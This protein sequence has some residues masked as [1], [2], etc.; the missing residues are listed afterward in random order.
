MPYPQR[1]RSH[2]DRPGRHE[3]HLSLLLN[4]L[5]DL[6]GDLFIAVHVS[7]GIDRNRGGPMRE[8][9]AWADG[10]TFPGRRRATWFRF[11][12]KA[13]VD[14]PDCS[15]VVTG[16]VAG[17]EV[18]AEFPLMITW[19]AE[20]DCAGPLVIDLLRE[21]TV[22]R[23]IAESAPNSGDY[24]WIVEPCGSET[25]GYQVRLNDPASGATAVSEEFF[26][27]ITCGGGE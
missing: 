23:T 8:I 24:E 11:P 3:N 6:P 4:Q 19:V 14:E 15:L 7:M 21:G 5:R 2:A 1:A 17:D 16:P 12:V 20:G 10:K 27:I 22:C 18:C 26:R 13:C 9:G 25:D